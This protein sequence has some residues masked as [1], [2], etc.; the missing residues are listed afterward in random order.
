MNKWIGYGNVGKD[1]DIRKV[2]DKMVTKFSLATNK[3]YIGSSGEKITDTQWHN[4]VIWG[5]LAETASKYVKKGT[6]LIVE[7]EVVYRS[8][9][10]KEGQTIYITEIICNHFYFTGKPEAKEEKK[11]AAMSDVS[12]LPGN[13]ADYDEI[14]D[15]LD[16]IPA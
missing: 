7:G 5:K 8:Y 16:S 9:E 4:I 11:S 15:D 2:N 3:N 6:P 12:E 14:P 1:P 13:V 10:N